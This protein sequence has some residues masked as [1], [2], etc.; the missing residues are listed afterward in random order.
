MLP[1]LSAGMHPSTAA[2]RLQT[3]L[4]FEAPTPRFVPRLVPVVPPTPPKPEWSPGALLARV[5]AMREV[6]DELVARLRVALEEAETR[7]SCARTEAQR[8][9]LALALAEALRR[10]P[11]SALCAVSP[12]NVTLV[13]VSSG[14]VPKERP[15]DLDAWDYE[16]ELD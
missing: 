3:S 11:L 10:P 13:V 7:V 4:D 16:M 6:P 9:E 8:D 1:A 12:T 2:L 5:R 15:D 14:P